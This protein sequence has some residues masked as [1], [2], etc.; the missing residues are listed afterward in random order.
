M[1]KVDEKG[2][3]DRDEKKK[4]KTENAIKQYLRDKFLRINREKK[5]CD[6]FVDIS[7][8]HYHIKNHT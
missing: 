6:I 8:V 7:E 4:L 2:Q 1:L 5:D 3:T